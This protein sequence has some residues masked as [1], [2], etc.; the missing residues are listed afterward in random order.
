MR[1]QR[2]YVFAPLTSCESKLSPLINKNASQNSFERHGARDWQLPVA[3]YKFLVISE[4]QI[5]VVIAG[6]CLEVCH[7]R[8]FQYFYSV[9]IAKLNIIIN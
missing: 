5:P 3:S 6:I 8:A 1:L 9:S 7:Q 4:C 2:A